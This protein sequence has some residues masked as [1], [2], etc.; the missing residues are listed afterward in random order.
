MSNSAYLTYFSCAK[1]KHNRYAI[2][3]LRVSTLPACHQ[4][5][6]TLTQAA[7]PNWSSVYNTGTYQFQLRHSITSCVYSERSKRGKLYSVQ[8]RRTSLRLE[9]ARIWVTSWAS[10]RRHSIHGAQKKLSLYCF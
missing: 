10:G 4:G 2:S 5:I 9:S 7:P 1:S 3:F 8:S 6:L